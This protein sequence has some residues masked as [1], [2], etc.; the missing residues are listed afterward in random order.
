VALRRMKPKDSGIIIQVGSALAYRS[1]PLQ[2]A[3]CGAKHAIVG[4]TEALRCELI[5]EKSRIEVT[6]VELPA[7]NTPQFNWIRNKMGK[8]SKPVGTIFQPEVAAEAILWA[9]MNPKKEYWLGMPTV[10]SIMGNRTAPALFDRYLAR[11]VYKEHLTNIPDSDSRAD[12][13]FFPV[14]VDYGVHGPYDRDSHMKSPQFSFAK[15]KYRFLSGLVAIS[16]LGWH[17]GRKRAW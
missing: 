12:N 10:E 11:K 3:Y 5:H 1:I 17:F 4:F 13:M 16:A 7:V 14:N 8:K 6:V 15:H 9:A 2:S